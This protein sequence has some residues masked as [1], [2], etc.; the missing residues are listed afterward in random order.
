MFRRI[1]ATGAPLDQVEIACASDAHV[2]LIWEKA[3]RH[4][5]PVTLGPGI[6]AALTRPG[7]GLI[8]FCHW[9]ETDF[10]AAHLRRMLQSRRYS[11]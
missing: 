5:W 3:L 9:I 6:G 4:G 11:P 1:L 10:S 8:A 2:S 7:R